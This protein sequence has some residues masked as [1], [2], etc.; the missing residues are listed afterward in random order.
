MRVQWGP[1]AVRAAAVAAALSAARDASALGPIDIEVAGKAGYGTSPFSQD[2]VNELGV[3]L[4]ARAGIVLYNVYVGGSY[5]YSF[6]GSAPGRGDHV[7]PQGPNNSPDL[8]NARST[9]YG[10]EVGYDIVLWRPTI[11][12]RNLA[13]GIRLRPAL[14]VGALAATSRFFDHYNTATPNVYL[15]PALDG[16]LQFGV[17]LVGADIGLLFLP[18]MSSSQPAFT[19]HGQVGVRF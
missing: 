12:T 6:G 15:E 10:G 11:G 7:V 5:M 17:L 4:G 13:L 3:E 1:F 9:R 14:G 8:Q 2:P 18:G 16:L 19:V